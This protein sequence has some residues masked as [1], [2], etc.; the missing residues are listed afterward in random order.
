MSIEPTLKPQRR[1]GRSTMVF[2]VAGTES[3]QRAPARRIDRIP[4]LVYIDIGVYEIQR[5][6]VRVPCQFCSFQR[7][8]CLGLFGRHLAQKYFS[9]TKKILYSFRYS[10]NI[11]AR[12]KG[13]N[14]PL[15]FFYHIG[16]LCLRRMCKLVYM[17]IRVT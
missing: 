15:K 3:V 16:S 13:I 6:A 14:K 11:H 1:H 2:H 5:Y 10:C 8:V 4:S 12:P 7:H 9:E 17:Y